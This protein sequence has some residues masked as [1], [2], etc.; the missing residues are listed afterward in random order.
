MWLHVLYVCI[1]IL[2]YCMYVC[3]A[4]MYGVPPIYTPY[5]KS[6]DRWWSSESSA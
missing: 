1:H 4:C 2:K 6:P 3:T 5:G